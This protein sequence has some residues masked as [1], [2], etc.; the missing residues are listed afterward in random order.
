[1]E[2]TDLHWKTIRRLFEDT[3]KTSFHYAL[4][5]VG[6]NGAPHVA[7]VGSLIL[8]FSF[9]IFIWNILK[10]VRSGEV[11]TADPWHG[12]TLEWS[13]PSPPQTASTASTVNPPAN[14]L[15]RLSSTRSAG[16]SES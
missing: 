6:E 4:A 5:T 12:A 15:R 16:E 3:F 7:P 10:S 2:I 14:T 11:A 1:M 8:G 13:I 9:L